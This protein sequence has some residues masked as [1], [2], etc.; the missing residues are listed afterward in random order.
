[1]G[2]LTAMAYDFL[3]HPLHYDYLGGPLKLNPKV[4]KGLTKN[5]GILPNIERLQIGPVRL[6]YRT[7]D[8]LCME[9]NDTSLRAR[10]RSKNYLVDTNYK[11]GNLLVFGKPNNDSSLFKS[12][13]ADSF[14]N[15]PIDLCAEKLPGRF[16]HLLFQRVII[17]RPLSPVSSLKP[18]L[19]MKANKILYYHAD[20]PNAMGQNHKFH[21]NDNT[22]KF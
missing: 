5:A 1:M 20:V 9:R 14:N 8:F 19:G 2:K 22:I 12:F 18:K 17:D 7:F 10:F 3:M 11:L 4:L 13:D 16:Y 15:R 6:E 21:K